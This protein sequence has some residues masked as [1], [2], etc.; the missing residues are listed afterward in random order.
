MIDK[1]LARAHEHV[2]A[3]RL[4]RAREVLASSLPNTDDPRRICRAL[5]DVC[6]AMGDSFQA[7]RFYLAA[8]DDPDETQRPAM[9]LFL[10]RFEK[11]GYRQLLTSLPAR[12]R[13][14]DRERYP[15]YLRKHL[16]RIGAPETFGAPDRSVAG[17]DRQPMIAVL[18]CLTG[19]VI[20]AA[21]SLVGLV[22]I[23]RWMLDV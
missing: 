21:C 18:T 6:L 20:V 12:C 16:E 14:T 2:V 1:T 5:G 19:L 15:L 11:T 8:I 9:E 4:G 23:I 3:G 22:T 17:A 10:S 7:G 13:S